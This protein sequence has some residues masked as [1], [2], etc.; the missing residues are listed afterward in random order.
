MKRRNKRKEEI[1]DKKG[2]E[3]NLNF[4]YNEIQ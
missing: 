2:K 4:K 3:G 1:K